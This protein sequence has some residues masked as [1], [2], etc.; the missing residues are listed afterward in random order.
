MTAKQNQSTFDLAT[1]IKGS[2]EA[3]LD[4]CLANE[5]SVTSLTNGPAEA[6][7]PL[8][9]PGRVL[10]AFETIYRNDDVANYYLAKGLELATGD[11]S[12]YA[13][14]IPLGIG[15]MIIKTNFDIS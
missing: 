6:E 8:L 9:V 13:V 10:L 7:N 11:V 15:T 2:A 14:A 5:L 1:Q 3:I 12:A 4:F